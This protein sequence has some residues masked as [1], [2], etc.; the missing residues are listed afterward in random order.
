MIKQWG[1][2][3]CLPYFPDISIDSTFW[4]AKLPPMFIIIL[5]FSLNK[6]GHQK[7]TKFG[8]WNFICFNCKWPFFSLQLSNYL[9]NKYQYNFF[10]EKVAIIFCIQNFIFM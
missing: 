10:D 3:L 5:G 9:K 8:L 6:K 7:W 4:W 2:V 1:L